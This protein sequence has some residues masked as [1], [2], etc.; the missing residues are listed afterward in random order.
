V[1]GEDNTYLLFAAGALA[2]A[3]LTGFLLAV[4]LPLAQVAGWSWGLRWQALAQA[5]G[6]AQVMGWAGLFIFGMGYRLVPRFTGVPL[7]GRALVVPSFWLLALA[8]A[9]RVALQ[10]LADREAARLALPAAGLLELAAA[11]V[12]AVLTLPPLLRSVRRGAG[13]A[14]YL[15]ALDVWLLVQAGLGLLWLWDA[16]REGLMIVPYGRNQVLLTVQFFGVLVTA[17]LGVSLRTVPVFFKRPLPGAGAAW[18]L[19]ALL[20]AGLAVYTVAGVWYV[21]RPGDAL[22]A[23]ETASLVAVAAG[24]VLPLALTGAWRSP[25]RLRPVARHA[26]R[27]VQAAYLWLAVAGVVLAYAAVDALVRGEPLSP[28]QGDAVRHVLALGTVTMMIVGMAHLITPAFAIPRQ[29]GPGPQWR[30]WLVWAALMVA[31]VLRVAGAWIRDPDLLDL[32]Y[33]AMA[34]AGVLALAAIALFAWSLYRGAR[35]PR[36]PAPPAAT[37]RRA[38][39]A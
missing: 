4:L 25:S 14:P 7:Q 31:T 9:L 23:V 22:R 34:V 36:L 12:F 24:A 33:G 3:L 6:H 29:H 16:S 13:F 26:A 15:V 32:R 2:A 20:Q 39:V 19:C 30:L 21:Y 37:G 38:D 5:H 17:I 8:V 35:T 27:F 1:G 18:P 10:P 28:Y 11:G